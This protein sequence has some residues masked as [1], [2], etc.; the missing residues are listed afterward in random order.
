MNEITPTTPEQVN[1]L[2]Y[3]AGLNQA[4]Y[5]A[6]LG[7]SVRRVRAWEN[8]EAVPPDLPPVV[9]SVGEQARVLR[10]RMGLSIRDVAK[11]MD[12]S[13]VTIINIER[14]RSKLG[15][16]MLKALWAVENADE[17]VEVPSPDD[18]QLQDRSGM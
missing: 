15:E 13:H 18:H 8:G 5:A 11:L 16:A 3:R 6:S 10:R 4:E 1:I 9:L 17:V 14:N 2:R 7:V 12:I